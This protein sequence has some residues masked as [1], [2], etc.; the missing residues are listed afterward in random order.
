MFIRK[1]YGNKTEFIGKKNYALPGIESP[2]LSLNTE[3]VTKI[4]DEMTEITSIYVRLYVSE[5]HT[6][7][8]K[9]WCSFEKVMAIKRNYWGEKYALPGIES[10]KLPLNTEKVT[11]ITDEMTEITS[12]YVRLYVSESHTKFHEDWCSFE[13]VMAIKLNL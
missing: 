6:K 7:F 2:K 1:S 5:S 4:T 3:N 12:V 8:H 10:P 13:K 9:D 11:E